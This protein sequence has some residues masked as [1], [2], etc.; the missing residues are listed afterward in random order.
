MT[1]KPT[2]SE[3]A[4]LGMGLQ[5]GSSVVDE[6]T[7]LGLQSGDFYERDHQK[8]WELFLEGVTDL[9]LLKDR[10]AQWHPE[11]YS[12][13]ASLSHD[14]P[15]MASLSGYVKMITDAA[16]LRELRSKVPPYLKLTDPHEAKAGI[17]AT[18]DALEERDK[19][20]DSMTLAELLE[21]TEDKETSMISVGIKEVDECISLSPGT[22][23]VVAGRPKMGKT[24]L[25][26]GW[27]YKVAAA[28][29]PV[30]FLSAEMGPVGL[31]RRFQG[32]EGVEA[33]LPL[34]F[35][36]PH[37]LD[38][39]CGSL[40]KLKKDKGIRFAVVDYLQLLTASATGNEEE[41]IGTAS[42]RFK[43]LSQELQIPL[44][45]VAQ[46]NRRPEERDDK[47]PRLSDLR[48]SGR[49]EQDADAVLMVYRPLY[50]EPTY[51]P[52]D[53]AEIIVRANRHGPTG[54]TI[55]AHWTPGKGWFEGGQS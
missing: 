53:A 9:A 15:T 48:G 8:L 25:A 46:V 28:G 27:A 38:A 36:Y 22:M 17:R 7:A 51:T 14:S 43:L 10:A 34:H 20:S 11:P 18:L 5:Y 4:L 40:R 50:Y 32:V 41:G 21:H 26:L 37:F 35:A 49:I 45:V 1:A 24:H 30:A 39:A 33:G 44:L 54:E 31:K 16:M 6:A 52:A 2:A 55:R 13:L 47:R 19:T 29:H 23:T 42:R 12:F 3:R